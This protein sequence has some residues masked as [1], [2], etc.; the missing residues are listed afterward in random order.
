MKI[1]KY[2]FLIIYRAFARYLPGSQFRFGGK[3]FKIFRAY[4][5]KHIFLKCGK[6]VNI[7]HGAF[8]GRGFNIELGDNSGIGYSCVVPD[9]IIIGNDVMMG[10]NCYI[11]GR[12][13]EINR[14]DIPM[15][16]QGFIIKNTIIED[17]VWIGR[18]VIFT[19]GR[20]V[21]KGSVIGAGCVLTKDFPEYS[22]IGGNPSCLIKSRLKINEN[23]ITT[24]TE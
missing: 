6:N 17:D 24:H 2:F 7:E 16:K 18:E 9:N 8:F 12:N 22:I 15:W 11:L 21:K 5:C 10:P 19:P 13:H 1:K 20:I 14:T 3:L 4:C 23:N